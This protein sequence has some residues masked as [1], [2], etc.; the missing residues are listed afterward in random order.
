MKVDPIAEEVGYEHLVHVEDNDKEV[1][2]N[3]IY[4]RRLFGDENVAR[5]A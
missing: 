4:F 5:D 1:E 2:S 3:D